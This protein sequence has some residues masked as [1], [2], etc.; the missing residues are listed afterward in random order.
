MKLEANVYTKQETLATN[1]MSTSNDRTF[2]LNLTFIHPH[3][4][5]EKELRDYG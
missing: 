2:R 1:E 3:S 5:E 4:V